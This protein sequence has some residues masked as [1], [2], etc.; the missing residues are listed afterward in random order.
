MIMHE[1]FRLPVAGPEKKAE[2][3]PGAVAFAVERLGFVPDGKQIGVLESSARR[4]ILLCS[5]QWGKSTVSAVKAVHRAATVPGSLVLVASPSERQSA[6]F[7]R[8][9][10][11]LFANWG[12]AE[13]RRG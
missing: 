3:R 2:A 9:A 12:G 5:R 7:V 1:E 11:S 8:K 13:G 6:E 4:G 10:K